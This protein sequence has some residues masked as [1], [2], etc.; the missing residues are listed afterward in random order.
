VLPPTRFVLD[1]VLP[2]PG[3]GPSEKM[4]REGFYEIEIHATAADGKRWRADVKAKGD[5]GYGATSVMLGE[6][7]LC[8]ALDTQQLP[9]RAGVVTPSS[10][11]GDV[12]ADRLRAAGQTF[13]VR[14]D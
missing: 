13:E 11:M 7:G 12:L 6:A 1:R 14:R 5:P 3:E 4:V 10:G 8:L 2:D 9:A